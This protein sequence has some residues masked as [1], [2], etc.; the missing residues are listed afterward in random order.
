MRIAV[1]S[2]DNR[3][4]DP[5][6]VQNTDSDGDLEVAQA[7]APRREDEDGRRSLAKETV[8]ARSGSRSNQEASSYNKGQKLGSTASNGKRLEEAKACDEEI[9]RQMETLKRLRRELRSSTIA[10]G[11]GTGT[12]GAHNDA[13][14]KVPGLNKPRIISN[15]Q[16]VLGNLLGGPL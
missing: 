14:N 6:Y 2:P 16:I 15:V 1:K 9:S 4:K 13:G 10:V 5:S 11:G 7:A 12:T 3:K 8:R